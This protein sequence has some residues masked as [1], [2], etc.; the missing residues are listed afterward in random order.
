MLESKTPRILDLTRQDILSV[1]S[2]ILNSTSFST[3]TEKLSGQ[4]FKIIVKDKTLYGKYKEEP[5]VSKRNDLGG[6]LKAFVNSRIY[7]ELNDTTFTFEVLK[8]ENRPDYIDYIIGDQVI[9]IEFSGNLT[10]EI[11]SKINNRQKNVKFLT[12]QDIIKKPRPLSPDLRKKIEDIYSFVESNKT[13]TKSNKQKIEEAIS[14]SLIEIFGDSIF[15]GPI[16]GVFVT[17]TEKSFKIPEKNYSNIQL[18]Q[19]PIYAVFSKKSTYTSE[20]LINRFENIAGHPELAEKDKIILDVRKYL[21]A[22]KR[23]FSQKGFR[24]FFTP[25]EASE[26]L[27]MLDSLIKGDSSLAYELYNSIRKRVNDR[28]GWISTGN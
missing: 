27:T 3:Y 17:N 28:S 15:G 26:L 23:K 9:A 20:Q 7:H 4:F 2:D 11:A 24:T 21:E 14:E 8:P 16:E 18:L 10:K 25:E 12:V 22:A 13:I 6:V 1:L 19:A 5:Y